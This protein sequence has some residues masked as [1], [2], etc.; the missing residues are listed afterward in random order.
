MNQ[1]SYHHENEDEILK[2]YYEELAPD[3]DHLRFKNSYGRYIDNQEREILTRWLGSSQSQ[4]ILDLACGTGRFL[5]F[6]TAGLDLSS[7]MIEV[8]KAK[9]PDKEFIQASASQI[10]IESGTYDAIFSL[11]LFM[12]LSKG[13]IQE[14]VNE[15][16]RILRPNGAFIF[17][18]PSA[19]RRKL[20]SYK[21]EDWHGATSLSLEDIHQ[22][23]QGKWKVEQLVGV[24]FLPIHRFPHKARPLLL[25][26]DKFLCNSSLKF[27]SSYYLVKLIKT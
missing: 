15:C 27:L 22:L 2:I 18:I 16:H 7:R 5:S 19:L 1:Q 25:P 8:A 6:A 24:N 14:I 4:S 26:V 13:K 11:H 12:H 10:P 9:Y 3:Y 21:A 20:I 23:G 17:D